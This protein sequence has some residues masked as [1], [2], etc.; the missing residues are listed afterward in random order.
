MS[1]FTKSIVKARDAV[2]LFSSLLERITVQSETKEKVFFAVKE[3]LDE[4]D[5]LKR[6]KKYL[7]RRLERKLV[8]PAPPSLEELRERQ[9]EMEQHLWALEQQSRRLQEKRLEERLSEPGP[10]SLLDRVYPS[11]QAHNL[12]ELGIKSNSERC[13]EAYLTIT[14]LISRSR[15][16]SL[17]ED[18]NSSERDGL[19][20][21]LCRGTQVLQ[22][23]W[24]E[25]AFTANSQSAPSSE[26]GSSDSPI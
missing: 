19:L 7:L 9:Q 14:Y 21:S 8:Q 5:E 12:K 10:S 23:T 6:K 13:I 17:S 2:K 20:T 1:K 22:S 4:I 25:F 26:D 24:R 11:I 16:T 3:K 15:S 18:Q